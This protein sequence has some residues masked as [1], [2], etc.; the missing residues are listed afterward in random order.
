M[1]NES[2]ME[3]HEGEARFSAMV[4]YSRQPKNTVVGI[5]KTL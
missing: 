4:R 5:V 2:E 3:E 1:P